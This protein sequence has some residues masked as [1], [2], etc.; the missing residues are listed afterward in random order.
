MRQQESKSGLLR[1]ARNGEEKMPLTQHD[2]SRWAILSI[3]RQDE[4]VEAIQSDA[5]CQVPFAK[6]FPFS[7]DP[8]HLHI[9][10]HPGPHKGAFRDRHGRRAG[11]AVDAGGA[12]DEGADLADG[13]VVWS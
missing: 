13:E 3:Y 10:R 1:Y 2:R 6:I 8:N 5:T 9:P 4:F 12:K 7:F 11:D